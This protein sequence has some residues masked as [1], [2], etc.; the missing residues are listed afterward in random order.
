M[1]IG[2]SSGWKVKSEVLKALSMSPGKFISRGSK[3]LL[4]TWV[5]FALEF[6]IALFMK[7]LPIVLD[8]DWGLAIGLSC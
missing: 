8:S 7:I 4:A 3:L 1:V 2:P 6:V 5:L